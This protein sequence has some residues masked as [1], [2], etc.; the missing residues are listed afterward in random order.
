MFRS[1]GELGR[2]GKRVRDTLTSITALHPTPAVAS[3]MSFSASSGLAITSSHSPR[4]SG[5]K[6]S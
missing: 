1:S 6:C 5:G 4:A 2:K 3:I